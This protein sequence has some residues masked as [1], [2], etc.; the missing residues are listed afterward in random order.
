MRKLS[1]TQ[2]TLL[3][4]AAARPDLSVLPL[5]D[6][7][8]KR[9]AALDRTFQSL[10]SHG[11]I[12][13]RTAEGRAE[14]PKRESQ[15]FVITPEGLTAI[16]VEMPLAA[17]DQSEGVPNPGLQIDVAVCP[18]RPGG[19][20]GVLL[21]AV[22]RPKGATLDELTTASGWLPHTTRAA[23]TRLRQRGFD[24]RLERT[25]ERKAYR[26]VPA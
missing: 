7:I 19:K 9:G 14:P 6:T 24:V 3:A 13:E 4:T 8:R 23:L 10:L 11:F 16:G 5:P 12:V 26:L 22:A 25:A 1:D 21:N 18:G 17:P 15:Q 2:A 20:L